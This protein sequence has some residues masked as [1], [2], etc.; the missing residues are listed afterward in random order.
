MQNE[1]S[2]IKNAQSSR[3]LAHDGILDDFKNQDFQLDQY[4]YS[5][6]VVSDTHETVLILQCQLKMS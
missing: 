1:D 5:A 2:L 4:H 6:I 3:N